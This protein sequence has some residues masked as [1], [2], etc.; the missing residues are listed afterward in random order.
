MNWFRLPCFVDADTPDSSIGWSPERAVHFGAAHVTAFL[1]TV[2]TLIRER[3][4]K[5]EDQHSD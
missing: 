2:P 4:S 1:H 5:G 3:A